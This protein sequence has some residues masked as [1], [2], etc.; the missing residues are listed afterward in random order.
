MF[1]L[2]RWASPSRFAFQGFPPPDLAIEFMKRLLDVT[3]AITR[4]SLEE[5]AR[6]ICRETLALLH[7]HNP[8]VRKVYFVAYYN[9]RNVPCL[10]DLVQVSFDERDLLEAV[11]VR[12]A[13]HDHEAI[14]PSNVSLGMWINSLQIKRQKSN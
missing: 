8:L 9:T 10:T 3:A 14:T 5:R 7:A 13:V 4:W 2:L 11:S 6:E 1:D 12:D